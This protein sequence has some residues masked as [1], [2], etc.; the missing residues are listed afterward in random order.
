MGN[1]EDLARAITTEQ[2]KTLADARGDVFR[3]LEVVEYAC[4]AASHMMGE[5]VENVSKNMDTYSYQVPLGVCAGIM[6]F[7]FPAMIPL[8]MFTLA[9][10]TGNTFLMKP[11]EIVPGASTILTDLATQAG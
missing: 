8:W 10:T 9:L 4:G 1:T 2:G 11:S 3:G 7:N 5:T 6:P